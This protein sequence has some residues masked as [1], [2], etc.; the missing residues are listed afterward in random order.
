M[1]VVSVEPAGAGRTGEKKPL[2]RDSPVLFKE[3]DETKE[4]HTLFQTVTRIESHDFDSCHDQTM[5]L[6]KW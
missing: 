1:L 3:H 6:I 4:L 5:S 2:L